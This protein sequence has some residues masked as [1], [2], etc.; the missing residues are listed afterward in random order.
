MSRVT[1]E[2]RRSS[3]VPLADGYRPSELA[4]TSG[5][6][7]FASSAAWRCFDLA[8]ALVSNE[9]EAEITDH[10]A[11][12][13]AQ[14]C[15]GQ[16]MAAVRGVVRSQAP[17]L[18]NFP[19]T[20][21]G[22]KLLTSLRRSFL[23]EIGEQEQAAETKQLLQIL[24]AME[25]VGEAVEANLAQR[26]ADQLSE[27]AAQNLVVEVAHDMRSPLGSIL[28]LTDQM[29]SGRSGALTPV[30]QQHLGLVYS[31]TFG[32]SSLVN[33]LLELARGG[34]RL[35]DH[36]PIPFSISD[37]LQSVRHIVQPIAEEKRLALHFVLPESDSRMGLPAA[38]N[39]VLLNL[40]TNALKF[41]STGSVTVAC[42]QISKTR[43]E[44]S[45]TDT[46]RGIPPR[47]LAALFDAFRPGATQTEMQCAFSS[48][49]LGLLI[50]RKLV[51]A[52]NGELTVQSGEGEGTRFQF[53][54]ELPAV[55]QI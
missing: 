39:R 23:A 49:G 11:A 55:S 37:V 2:V 15:L 12:S 22:R 19:P 7:R 43:F 47:V 26:F 34:D 46:G 31:A 36:D 21:S 13:E 16:L 20:V 45:V 3:G 8:G 30:Q 17:R 35:A 1:A 25:Q 10:W 48:A 33:D 6:L 40:A 28:L 42:R 5:D 18:R 14:R 50:C 27:R 9:I 29:K 24:S 4:R 54:L 41:T 51:R 32:L 52:M 53:E 38:L 44:F